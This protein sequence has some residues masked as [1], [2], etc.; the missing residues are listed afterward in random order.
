[1]TYEF[2]FFY[3]VCHKVYIVSK[4]NTFHGTS[5]KGHPTVDNFEVINT[6]R[7]PA[8]GLQTDTLV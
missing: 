6:E 7:L 8:D 1:M 4:R 5:R 2:S 3:F